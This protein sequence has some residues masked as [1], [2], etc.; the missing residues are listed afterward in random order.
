MG[1]V[2][3]AGVRDDGAREEGCSEAMPLRRAAGEVRSVPE[4]VKDGAGAKPYC[5]GSADARHTTLLLGSQS[6][7]PCAIAHPT[8]QPLSLS[9]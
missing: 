2:V 7:V 1:G 5:C 6:P 3:F 4:E 8:S 9:R